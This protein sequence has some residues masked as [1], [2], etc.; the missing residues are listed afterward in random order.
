MRKKEEGRPDGTME[1][2]VIGKRKQLREKMRVTVAVRLSFPQK[3][4]WSFDP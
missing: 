3:K 4:T 2:S 1:N